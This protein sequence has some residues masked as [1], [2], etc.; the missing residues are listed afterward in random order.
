MKRLLLQEFHT[1]PLCDAFLREGAY[2]DADGS[3][4]DEV[5]L[6]CRES[7]TRISGQ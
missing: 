4:V 6:D 7:R 1:D 2:N 5:V 3:G